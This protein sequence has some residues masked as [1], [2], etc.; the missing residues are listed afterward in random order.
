MPQTIG[1]LLRIVIIVAV[2]G[3]LVRA[4]RMA[5]ARRR[6]AV[7]IWKAIRPRHIAGSLGLMVVVLGVALTLL[8]FVPVTGVGLGQVVG[9]EGNAVFAPID[10]ALEAPLEA[11]VQA[12]E[13]GS[14]AP[15]TPWTDVAVVTMFLGGLVLLF[16][17]LAHAE[18][19]AFRVGWE[20][21]TTPQQV[22]SALWFGLIHMVMLIPLAAALAVGVAGYVY[23]RIYVRAYH[24][25]ARPRL[26]IPLGTGPRLAEDD[27]GLTRLVMGPPSP[28]YTVDHASA[29][30]QA[31]FDAA[32]WHTT[33][34][35][36]VAVLVWVGYVVSL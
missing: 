3:L 1:E 12:Q 23:G 27:Q 35:T 8:V 9:L 14:P 4:A 7:R 18:E 19:T 5:W 32:V 25:V 29:R 33:F 17:H 28:E 10:D 15:G 31:A 11:A 34:N 21:L 20:N 22:L 16:P 6:L 13:S 30:R 2:L 24:R 26:V 36:T